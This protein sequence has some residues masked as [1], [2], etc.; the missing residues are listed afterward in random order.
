MY[1]TARRW[2]VATLVLTGGIALALFC[3]LSPLTVA[4]TADD[5]EITN[6]IGIKLVR[7]PAGKFT[8]G[9]PAGEEGRSEDEEQHEVEITKGFYLGK[10]EVTRGQF[11]QF[12]KD[13]GYKTD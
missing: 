13:T 4:A 5:S 3:G 10:Y 8:M 2:F 7:I 11:R 1:L 9:S 12:V 6:G